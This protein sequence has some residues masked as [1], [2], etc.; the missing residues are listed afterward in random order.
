MQNGASLDKGLPADFDPAMKEN[1]NVAWTA[2]FGGRSTPLVMDG[3]V[4]VMHGFGEGQAESERV[5]CV[6][7]KTG[8]K[9]WEHVER[10]YHADITSSRLGWTPR[11]APPPAP[12]GGAAHRP[13][14]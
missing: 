11:G 8:K 2:P 13:H 9:L 14:L 3:R 6:E 1:G 12:T 4:Y 5:V 10:I 7:E